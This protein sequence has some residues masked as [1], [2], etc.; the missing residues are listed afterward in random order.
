M[1]QGGSGRQGHRDG[2]V[3]QPITSQPEAVWKEEV[4]EQK[5]EV[6]YRGIYI[7]STMMWR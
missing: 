7:F 6:Q 5:L 4:K 1:Y 3:R 2:Q